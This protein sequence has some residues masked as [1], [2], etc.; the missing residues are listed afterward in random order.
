MNR[1]DVDR[2]VLGPDGDFW[3]EHGPADMLQRKEIERRK[4]AYKDLVTALK[5]VLMTSSRLSRS[6]P[7]P[8]LQEMNDHEARA[9]ALLS[10]LGEAA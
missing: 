10:K 8:L 9:A 1:P 4:S 5:L 7:V 6:G 2:V 3:S